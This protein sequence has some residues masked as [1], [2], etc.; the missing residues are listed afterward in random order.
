MRI[1]TF[2]PIVNVRLSTNITDDGIQ[3][4]IYSDHVCYSNPEW[5]NSH[6]CNVFIRGHQIPAMLLSNHGAF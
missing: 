4:H 3:N 2:K 5:V 6:T 1:R